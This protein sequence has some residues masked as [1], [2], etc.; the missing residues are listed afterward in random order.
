M[1]VLYPQSQETHTQE[2]QDIISAPPSWLLTWGITL[3]FVVLIL[4]FGMTSLIR[5]PDIVKTQVIINSVNSPKPVVAKRSGKLIKILVQENQLIKDGQALA[6]LEST[7]NH[8][9]V[10]ELLGNLKNLQMKFY[11]TNT[12]SSELF[13][14]PGILQLG[15]VQGS[16]QSFFQFYLNYKASL[17]NGFYQRKRKYLQEELNGI[18]RQKV[19]IE[20]QKK[21]QEREYEIAEQEYSSY[22]KLAENRV[23][24]PM[25]LKREESKL[26]V[27][28]Y[29][30]QQTE[31]NFIT[32]ETTYSIKEKEILELN[33]Q[34]QEERAIFIQALNSLVS[35]LENWKSNYVLSASQQG[36]LAF[37]G[38]IQQNQFVNTGQELFYVNPG[39]TNFFA[40]MNIPQ[41]NMGKVKVGQEV[42]I[43]LKSYP[44]EEY[45]M[46]RGR[47]R[48][49]A[50]I[51]YR[52][53]VFVSKVELANGAFSELKRPLVLKNGMNADA[54]IIT[55]DASLLKRL[56]RNIN[57][58]IDIKD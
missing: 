9:Q 54:E 41:Y 25:E 17:S 30:L 45:G 20:T 42:L 53:S 5:Y 49:L 2:M 14:N 4:I 34:I 1:P 38:I 47:I 21:I 29:P 26:L 31:S 55:E 58:M 46:I 57:K 23:I 39:N 11:E 19:Q 51:P 16:Y 27:K 52:D 18:R 43:K 35:E 10:L 8:M 3:F 48:Y 33:N 28:K 7:A 13:K 15:E 56:F 24:A 6:Y 37:A 12:Y 50:D 22:Q 44:Y 36:K 40:E 32:N